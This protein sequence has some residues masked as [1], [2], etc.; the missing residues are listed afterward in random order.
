MR[1][2]VKASF[3]TWIGAGAMIIAALVRGKVFAI[4]LGPAGVGTISQL[5]GF[6]VAA[7][8]VGSLSLGSGI[9]Q[10]VAKFAGKGEMEDIRRVVQVSIAL[11]L[12]LGVLL[13]LMVWFT[14]SHWSRWL[15]NGDETY[16]S[17]IRL[18]SISIVCF[19]LTPTIQAVLNGLGE[20]F[21]SSTVEIILTPIIIVSTFFLLKW[22]KIEGAILCLILISILRIAG[23]V[24]GLLRKHRD[25]FTNMFRLIDRR[26]VRKILSGL[27]KIAIGSFII[28]QS[29]AAV[30]LFVRSRIIHLYSL[31]VN[32]LYQAAFAVSSQVLV[33]AMSF[34]SAYAFSKVNSAKTRQERNQCTNEVLQ[35]SF[36]V[37]VLGISALTLLRHTYIILLLSP[38][39]L[40]SES[41]FPLQA[42]GEGFRQIGLAIGLGMILTSGVVT[43]VVVGL[44]WAAS[45][46]VFALI[47][48]PMGFWALPLHYLISGIIYFTA[49]WGVM[50]RYDQF[51]MNFQNKKILVSSFFLLILLSMLPFTFF[52]ICSGFVMV[53]IW[54]WFALENYRQTI[55][56]ELKKVF[57][58]KFWINK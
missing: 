50:S 11:T 47:F 5:S 54:C 36:L 49:S 17:Y 32:G 33:P 12:V 57:L 48:L 58:I 34:I 28:Q 24:A 52:A 9:A 26:A 6:V 7:S 41:L 8:V 2:I 18:F 3:I 45:N 55:L 19:S 39:F 13:T 10:Y 51:A 21:I 29:D 27:I 25:L 35:L 44:I 20:A 38:K 1:D 23:Q 40:R 53:I 14:A 56:K 4:E 37:V 22:W 15:F 16:A 42:A 43:W 46:A 31:E 30:Q